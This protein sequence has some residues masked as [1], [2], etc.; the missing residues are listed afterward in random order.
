MSV[1][2][3]DL[4]LCIGCKNCVDICP[5]DVFYFDESAKKSII[6]YP[7][8]CQGCGQCFFNCKGRSLGM[9]NDMYGYAIPSIKSATTAP[10]N[11]MVL[12]APGTISFITKG[13]LP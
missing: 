13:N 7:E 6:A 8:N 5:M 4:N 9:T 1:V 12:T 3:I 11:R 10:Q 2:R